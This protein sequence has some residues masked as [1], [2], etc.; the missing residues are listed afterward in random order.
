MRPAPRRE[1][2]LALLAT[3]GPLSAREIATALQMN[4]GTVNSLI[5]CARQAPAPPIHI[6]RYI[7]QVGRQGRPVPLFCAGAAKDA[8][9]P[10]ASPGEAQQRYMSKFTPQQLAER[11]RAWRARRK[12][13]T[14]ESHGKE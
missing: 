7:P 12:A 11:R 2:I 8:P 6:A 1:E 13:A 10:A 9:C 5:R 3:A 4:P 14:S